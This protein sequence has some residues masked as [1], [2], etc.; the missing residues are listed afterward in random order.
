[1]GKRERRPRRQFSAEFKTEAVELWQSSGKSVGEVAKDLDL[2]ETALRDWVKRA[3]GQEPR[4]AVREEDEHSELLRLRKENQVLQME[5][6]FPKK[7]ATFFARE[8][9][10]QFA[11]IRAEEATYPVAVMCRLLNVSRSGYYAW[12][13]QEPSKRAKQDEVLVEH[14]R[15]AH[16]VGRRCYGSPRIHRELRARGIRTS[17]KRVARLMCRE[18]LVGR[19][20]RSFR[21]TT[22]SKHTDPIAPNLL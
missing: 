10:M 6:D 8:S 22:D 11:C 12:K 15:E 2:T 16:R 1:M 7:A 3:E 21:R 20:P 19:R 13:A 4:R 18:A 9:K 14:A 5:R 17:K